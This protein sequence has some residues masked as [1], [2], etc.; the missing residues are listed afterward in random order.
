MPEFDLFRLSKGAEKYA[1]LGK[2]LASDAKD[3][4]MDVGGFATKSFNYA[5]SDGVKTSAKLFEYM[6]SKA[7]TKNLIIAGSLTAISI[8]IIRYFV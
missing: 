7:T 2:Q 6:K 1:F 5:V 4:L 8:P 3:F